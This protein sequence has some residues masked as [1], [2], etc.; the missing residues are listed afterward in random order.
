VARSPS[1]H[2]YPWY[3]DAVWTPEWGNGTIIDV[4][5]DDI[6]CQFEWWT[7][8]LDN[9]IPQRRTE[10]IDKVNF[11]YNWRSTSDGTGY[12]RLEDYD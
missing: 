6:V 7:G 9:K 8:T 12:W 11:Q 3:R 4:D 10:T 1:G 5:G 2:H